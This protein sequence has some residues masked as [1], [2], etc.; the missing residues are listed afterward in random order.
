MR[1]IALILMSCFCIIATAAAQEPSLDSV[2]T[3]LY[4]VNKVFDSSRYLAFDVVYKIST[5]TSFGKFDQDQIVVSYIL[6]NRNMYYK[7]GEEEFVQTDS[8]SYSIYNTDQ[9][10]VMTREQS[11]MLS[12]RFPLK[13]FLDSIITWYDS[14]Y[15]IRINRTDTIH[16]ISFVA[17][18]DTLPYSRFAIYYQPYSYLPVAIETETLTPYDWGEAPDTLLAKVSIKPVRHRAVMQFTNYSFPES[19]EI[20]Q[21]SQY[22][23]YDRYRRQYKLATRYRDYRLITNDVTEQRRDLK[24]EFVPDKEPEPID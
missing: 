21:D 24:E 13:E 16:S 5:D 12:N 20:F 3:E 4:H 18:G 6:N 9:L 14:A 22:A 15:S 11:V 19:L 17:R 1:R 23:V 10:I 7:A 2:K 8:F